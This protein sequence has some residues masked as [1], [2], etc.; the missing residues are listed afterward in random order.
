M[1][2]RACSECGRV[3]EI[4]DINPWKDKAPAFCCKTC[5]FPQWGSDLNDIERGKLK[6]KIIK[7][8]IKNIFAVFAVWR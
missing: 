4:K 3:N 8:K 1:I 2:Y 5:G 7:E 6:W